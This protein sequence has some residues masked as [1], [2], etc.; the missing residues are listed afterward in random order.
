MAGV[1]GPNG[2]A[3]RKPTDASQRNGLI[4]NQMRYS[5]MGGLTGPSKWTQK[6]AFPV[7]RATGRKSGHSTTGKNLE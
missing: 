7:Q 2:F 6:S 3:I 4:F 1:L 5:E